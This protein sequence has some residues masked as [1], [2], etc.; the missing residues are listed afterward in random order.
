MTFTNTVR[1][2]HINLV[3]YGK[4]IFLIALD[5]LLDKFHTIYKLSHGFTT[6]LHPTEIVTNF[7]PLLQMDKQAFNHSLILLSFKCARWSYCNKNTALV[8][9]DMQT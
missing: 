4:L 1:T 5:V 8:T 2:H 9:I 6:T 7:L 3:C